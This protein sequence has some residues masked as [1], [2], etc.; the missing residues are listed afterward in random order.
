MSK[1][2]LDTGRAAILTERYVLSALAES[3]DRRF[4]HAIE[5]LE[6]AGKSGGRIIV[7]GMG[8]SGHI[9]RK[10]AATLAST[11]TPAQYVHPGEASH[12]DLGMI[13]ERDAVI[14]MSNSGEAPEL[15]DII[16]YTRRFGIP[17]IAIT[18]KSASTLAQHSDIVLLL[19]DVPEACPN[20]LTPTTSTTAT[21]ALGDAL[22]VTL[23]ERKGL[24]AEQYRVFHPGGKLGQRLKRVADL[25]DDMGA[26]PLVS[27]ATT[28]DK[29][30]L[31]MT[32]KNVGCV[33]VEDNKGGVA[34]II[35]DG[36]LK[37]HMG[38]QL[39]TQ[40]AESV[41]TPHPKSIAPDALAAEAVDIMLKRF[42]QPITSLLVMQDGKLI[43]LIRL[44]AC[45]Q[46]GVI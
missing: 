39:L 14:A 1:D 20:G 3:L 18:A 21:M 29:T 46:A 45:L 38:P 7:T 42:K 22:A 44:Q 40:T 34:G 23:L 24:T 30:L 19:P 36:D 32:E 28:M 16:A 41:M 11:G 6:K 4:V 31:V 43:G 12:G 17:L 35:T 27:P 10:I 15:S 33:I 5:A 26:L 9:A 25:M 37:R 13:T 2:A 8:K